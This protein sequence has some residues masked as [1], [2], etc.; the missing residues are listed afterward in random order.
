MLTPEEFTELLSIIMALPESE[1]FIADTME[2]QRILPNTHTWSGSTDEGNFVQGMRT[3]Q[4]K[5]QR[6]AEILRDGESARK[7]KERWWRW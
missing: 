6:A 4:R 3:A 2:L 1:R 7:A 5:A